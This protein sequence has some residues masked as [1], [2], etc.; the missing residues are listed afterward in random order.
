MPRVRRGFTLIEL[1]LVI[2]IIAVLVGLLLPAVQKVREAAARTQCGNN[3]RQ[4]GLALHNYESARGS[5]PAGALKNPAH[6]WTAALLPYLEQ[7][8]VARIYHYEVNWNDPPNYPAV[9][10]R[11]KVYACPSAPQA[12][13]VDPSIPA[14]PA[15]GD[16]ASLNAVRFELANFYLNL[17]P[18]ATST[19]DPRLLGLLVRGPAARVA[20]V[21]DGT[22][23]TL[24][25]TESA[26]KPNWYVLGR[27]IPGGFRSEAGWADAAGP[28]NLTGFDPARYDPAKLTTTGGDVPR[29]LTPPLPCGVNCTNHDEIYAF[30]PGGANAVFADG[31]VRFLPAGIPIGVLAALV[32]R[33]G[34]EVTSGEGY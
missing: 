19:A 6:A 14:L 21:T 33:A 10:A 7:D 15:A 30:H 22:S 18:P 28:F 31:S 34:G 5:F 29:P 24:A 17:Q 27:Q 9:R 32:T 4:I 26:G 20:D 23:T 2:A 1:L 13:R 8:N 25:V 3:L 11:V 12:D 16:Y